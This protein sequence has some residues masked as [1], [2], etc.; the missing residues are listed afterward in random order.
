[1]LL[2]EGGK[3]IKTV[4]VGSD[5]ESQL[6]ELLDTLKSYNSSY[7]YLFSPFAKIKYLIDNAI[8]NIKVNK[9]NKFVIE[10]NKREYLDNELRKIES[11]EVLKSV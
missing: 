2:Y 4:P 3:I 8:K 7:E 11:E 10:I 6:E 9:N 1:M 5:V